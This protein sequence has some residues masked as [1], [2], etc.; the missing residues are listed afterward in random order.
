METDF[1]REVSSFYYCDF[2]YGHE[3]DLG[4]VLTWSN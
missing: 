2:F 3:I 4:R 1:L